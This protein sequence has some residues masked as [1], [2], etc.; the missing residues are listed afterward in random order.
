MSEIPSE[1]IIH[2]LS[3]AHGVIRAVFF[4]LSTTR[5]QTM[6]TRQLLFIKWRKK[7]TISD[8]ALSAF[9]ILQKNFIMACY[10]VGLTSNETIYCHTIK[11]ATVTLYMSD[12]AKLTVLN[13]KPDP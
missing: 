4:A 2:L 9:N 6:R 3:Y 11:S 8:P 5:L 7:T 13:N 12:A 10:T 1:S